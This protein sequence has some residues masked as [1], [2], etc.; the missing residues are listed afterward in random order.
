MCFLLVALISAVGIAILDYAQNGILNLKPVD[1]LLHSSKNS[2]T[3]PLIQ[4]ESL[5][6]NSS[7]RY[8]QNDATDSNRIR[9]RYLGRIITHSES[10]GVVN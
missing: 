10:E 9:S 3:Q 7:D 5:I 8:D 6:D 1:R 4:P 2:E